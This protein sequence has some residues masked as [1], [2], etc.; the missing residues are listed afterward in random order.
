MVAKTG[1]VFVNLSV[2]PHLEDTIYGLS[3]IPIIRPKACKKPLPLSEV[4]FALLI[5]KLPLTGYIHVYYNMFISNNEH[6]YGNI[7]AQLL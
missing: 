3:D 4:V 2:P 7:S 1:Y 6:L 5:P